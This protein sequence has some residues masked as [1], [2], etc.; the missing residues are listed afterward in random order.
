MLTLPGVRRNRLQLNAARLIN[1]ANRGPRR[2]TLELT[3][4]V[5]TWSPPFD[6]PPS[7]SPISRSRHGG[8]SPDA[9]GTRPADASAPAPGRLHGPVDLPA[10][11]GELEILP[12]VAVL[13]A[14]GEAELDLGA[15]VLEVELRRHERETALPDLA[16]EPVDLAAVE[17]ELPRPV[18]IRGIVGREAGG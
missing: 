12:L 4:S 2:A 11:L 5:E 14:P 10:A 13:L 7:L 18:G 3:T 1:E 15:A 8:S 9:A 16:G 17:E 6:D